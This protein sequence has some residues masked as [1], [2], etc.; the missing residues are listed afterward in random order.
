[1]ERLV[2]LINEKNGKLEFPLTHWKDIIDVH[3][4]VAT[5]SFIQKGTGR[6]VQSLV[7]IQAK[8]IWG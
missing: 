2:S 1:M 8:P 6:I 5:I 4:E 7:E 3:D